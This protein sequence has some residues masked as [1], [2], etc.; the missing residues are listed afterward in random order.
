MGEKEGEGETERER[1]R[2]VINHNT[3]DLMEV[4]Q[5]WDCL[6]VLQEKGQLH[7]RAVYG[8]S[9]SSQSSAVTHIDIL[10]SPN[11]K[12]CLLPPLTKPQHIMT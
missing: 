5:A 8:W 3:L 11:P 1:K 10:L 9:I 4:V 2:E 12:N 6:L 7:T